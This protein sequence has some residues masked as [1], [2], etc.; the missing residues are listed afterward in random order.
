M[1]V[2]ATRGHCG[3]TPPSEGDC[4]SGER[5]SWVASKH[6]LYTVD[7]CAAM[8]LRVCQRCSFVSFSGANDD[9]SWYRHCTR[10]GQMAFGG[11]KYLT[12]QARLL[13]G[14][15][16]AVVR[17]AHGPVAHTT[18][19]ERLR[20]RCASAGRP[21]S[22]PPE[23]AT[24]PA[25]ASAPLR[26]AIATLLV[27]NP[28]NPC[29][30][31]IGCALLPWCESARRLQ[32]A[33]RA[34]PGV[35]TVDLLVV[36]APSRGNTTLPSAQPSKLCRLSLETERLDERDCPGMRRLLPTRAMRVASRAHASRVIAS[37]V[38][39]YHPAYVQ[40][41]ETTLWKWE[42]LRLGHRYDAVLH[43]DVDT[44]ILPSPGPSA[45]Q[46]AA[47]W[48]RELPPLVARS[49]RGRLRLLGFADITTPLNA[50]LYWV[51][52]PDDAGAFYREGLSVLSAPWN[53]SYGWARAGTPAHL[54]ADTPMR[55]ANGR[56][57][58]AQDL[59]A[60]NYADW[61]K[62]DSG[63]LD[64]GFLLYM[65]QA[66]T[67][68]SVGAYVSRSDLSHRVVHYVGGREKPWIR[69]LHYVPP[70]AADA[71]CGRMLE[72][73]NRSSALH[74][75]QHS[76]H[77]DLKQVQGRAWESLMRHAYL[78]GAG[79]DRVDLPTSPCGNAF[80]AAASE[81]AGLDRM[82]CCGAFGRQDPPYEGSAGRIPLMVF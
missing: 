23:P 12:R 13:G 69:A 21:T 67:R 55:A 53:A 65:T 72:M 41:H 16:K 64:Q 44:D 25:G 60:S 45:A 39:S 3:Q 80:R 32:A 54:F 48:V 20:R 17:V 9:C 77:S 18:R 79:L 36:H 51:F 43:T 56:P 70:L 30:H 46:V 62:V 1:M 34:H 11:S 5:G 71:A 52:P 33:L 49:R 22:H 10:P 76:L 59:R 81:L 35:T 74:G 47:E 40:R 68:P 57:L 75:P 29:L 28:F 78:R 42:L 58:A 82:A 6:A 50:G 61:T 63:D 66:H 14:D 37:G 24:R 19:W 7:D 26:L 2:Q 4:A 73:R 15:A 31:G 8:C 38:M 27:P